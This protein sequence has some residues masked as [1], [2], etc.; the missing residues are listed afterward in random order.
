MSEIMPLDLEDI[1]VASKA[2][3]WLLLGLDCARESI[4]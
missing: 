1:A 4:S 3:L 2:E